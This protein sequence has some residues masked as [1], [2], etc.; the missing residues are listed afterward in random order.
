MEGEMLAV[1][2]DL[3]KGEIMNFDINKEIK[4]LEE[5]IKR[6]T[7]ETGSLIGLTP[8]AF[9]YLFRVALFL[10]KKEKAREIK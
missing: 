8:I 6:E 4:F 7:R 5:T 1:C 10:L 9:D 3:R 2:R